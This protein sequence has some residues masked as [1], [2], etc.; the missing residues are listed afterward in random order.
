[1]SDA[2]HGL[3][4]VH[5]GDGKGKTTAA[6]GLLL[7]ARGQGLRAGVI[8]FIKAEGAP[9][10]EVI[11][12][13]ELGIEWLRSGTGFVWRPDDAA[14]SR[15]AALAGWQTAQAQIV[16][17][18]YDILLLDEFTYP[19]AWGWLDPAA[20]LAW[21]TAHRP[22]TL[23]LII[24]GRDAPASLIAAADLVTEFR[25]IKHPFARGQRAQKGIEF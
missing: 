2:P 16:S 7:R 14:A 1:M 24:T 18:A 6:L 19:L 23:H 13:R 9:W 10:G 4:I 15:A 3:L 21:L 11:A 22:P 17:G 20:V 8:Q 12:G 25:C 5:T